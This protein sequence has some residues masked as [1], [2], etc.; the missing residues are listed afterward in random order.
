MQINAKANI[1]RGV[2]I[3]E[4]CIIDDDVVIASGVN[5]GYNV[6][7]RAGVRIGE[8]SI[9]CDNVVLGKTPVKAAMSAITQARQELPP[10]EIGKN[11]TV[12]AGCIIYRGATVGDNVFIG[13]MASI[14][15][16]V[17]VGELTIIGRGVA[18]EN[19]VSIG[20]KV[21]IET[22]A[23]ITALSVIEDYCFIAPEVTFTNDNFL[24]RTEERKKYFKG[25]TLRR[26]ARVGANATVLPAVEVGADALIAAG[27]VV[28]KDVPE[29]MVVMG[30]PA[31]IIREAPTEQSIENQ[32][33][34]DK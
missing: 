15:E 3:N 6:V 2:K 26:G 18:V 21:K 31:R 28:T 33:F 5:V 29:R 14:R 23:Y 27:S 32:V 9:V 1:A 17:D 20:R 30:N 10:L 4:G 7:I 16:N 34:Y 25:V 13:D 8:G 11:V 12:G 19:K 24:G 22:N